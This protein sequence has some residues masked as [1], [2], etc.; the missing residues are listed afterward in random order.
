MSV[1]TSTDPVV[2]AGRQALDAAARLRSID[3]G[4]HVSRR[5]RRGMALVNRVATLEALC[6]AGCTVDAA[7]LEVDD[8]D[9]HTGQGGVK[10]RAAYRIRDL[11]TGMAALFR[12]FEA[13]REVFCLVMTEFGRTVR[14]NGTGGTDHGHGSVVFV[15]GPR[16]KGGMHGDWHG[17]EASKLWEGRDLPVLTDYRD[18]AAEVLTTYSGRPLAPVVFPG[19][20]ATKTGLL[21]S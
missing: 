6:A 2:V 13:T 18:I 4:R 5:P 17:L 9:T 10:G 21:V 8:W 14:P 1:H 20:R 11:A 16:A 7:F 19:H 15:A 12:A 3:V